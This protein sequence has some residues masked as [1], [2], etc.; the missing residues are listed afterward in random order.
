M[1]RELLVLG[2]ALFLGCG[3]DG[4]NPTVKV[5]SGGNS[6]GRNQPR[7]PTG[8]SENAGSGGDSSDGGS[9]SQKNDGGAGRVSRPPDGE[10][11][12]RFIGRFTEDRS[13]AW[14][15]S[16]IELRFVGSEISVTLDDWG[17]NYFEVIIDGEHQ[18][19]ALGEGEQT[20][21]LASGLDDGEHELLLYRRSEAFFGPTRFV[22][23]SVPESDWL[24]AHAPSDRRLEVIAD[25]TATGYGI[26]GP[27]QYC[28][29]D[30]ETENHY[31]AYPAL[32]AR[33]VDA[34]V[35]TIAWSGI[36]VY[37]DNDGNTENTMAVRY[38]RAIP[39]DDT[40]RWDFDR[41]VP[42][43]VVVNL[44]ANDFVADDPGSEF[45]DA[46]DDLLDTIRSNYPDARIYLAVGSS[47]ADSEYPRLKPRLAAIAES[48][49]AEG[50]DNIALIDFGTTDQD[51]SYACDWHP[52]RSTHEQMAE[53]LSQALREDLGWF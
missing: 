34:E 17:H 31:I 49:R 43:A 13:F 48:R 52:S 46:Y 21:E 12:P 51:A 29:F 7:Q 33:A 44:G 19:I 50:D 8:G 5:V 35:H 42:D 18:V 4:A 9:A 45:E 10:P 30:A 47:T 6:D 25:S 20:Y 2:C 41:F 15:G 36:G 37:R 27:D 32:T 16:A 53:I 38:P 14:S 28:G 3:G 26:E 39:T 1:K 40:S 23:F 22:G 24:P 11:G